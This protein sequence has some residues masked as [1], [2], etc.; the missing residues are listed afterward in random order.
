[1]QSLK[2]LDLDLYILSE[3]DLGIVS[4]QVPARRQDNPGAFCCHLF[5]RRS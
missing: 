2:S 1:M 4:W 5:S 3:P